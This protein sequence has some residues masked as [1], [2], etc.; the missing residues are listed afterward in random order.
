GLYGRLE[1]V[2][3][4]PPWHL[5]QPPSMN[6]WRPRAIALESPSLEAW[7][8]LIVLTN[9]LMSSQS[10]WPHAAATGSSARSLFDAPGGALSVTGVTASLSSWPQSA[11]FAAVVIAPR[12]PETPRVLASKSWISSLTPVQLN[13]RCFCGPGPWENEPSIEVV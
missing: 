8:G 10:L 6:S 12:P 4:L 1:T 2:Q 13:M 9:A 5:A 7:T 11:T 3:P